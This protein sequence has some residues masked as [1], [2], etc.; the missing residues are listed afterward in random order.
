MKNL[1]GIVWAPL[2]VMFSG[3]AVT[4]KRNQLDLVFIELL[5]EVKSSRPIWLRSPGEH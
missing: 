1:V 5:K 2:Y 4:V 3:Y